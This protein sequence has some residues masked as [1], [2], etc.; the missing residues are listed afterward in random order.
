MLRNERDMVDLGQIVILS[1][2]PEDR[3]AV[4]SGR[5]SLFRQLDRRQRLENREQRPAKQTNL[6]SRNRRQRSPPEPLNIRQSLGRSP[7]SAI[8]SLENFANLTRDA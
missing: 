2:Q 4:H 8:L 1:G 6:L 5:R 3:D 7:P